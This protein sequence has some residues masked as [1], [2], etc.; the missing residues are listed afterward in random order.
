MQLDLTTEVNIIAL[1]FIYVSIAQLKRNLLEISKYAATK[2]KEKETKTCYL[3]W[4]IDL[5]WHL[6][7]NKPKQLLVY[8]MHCR[9]YVG[10]LLGGL[11]LCLQH[12][13][14]LPRHDYNCRYNGQS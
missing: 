3:H 12:H 6:K 1:T 8:L 9:F 2:K 7:Y 13:L 14:M 10:V 5:F 4:V 11:L